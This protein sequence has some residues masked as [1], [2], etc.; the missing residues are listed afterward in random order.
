MIGIEEWI[1]DLLMSRGALVESGEDGR[2]R[3][4]LPSDVAAPLGTGEW[5]SLDFRPVPGGDDAFEWMERMEHILP[6]HPLLVG[7]RMRGA[8]P[9][10]ALDATATLASELAIQNGI[11]RLVDDYSTTAPYLVFTFRYTVESDERSLGFFTACLNADACSIVAQPEIF[12]NGIREFLEEDHWAETP[13][14]MAKH[15]PAAA[16]AA[17]A[18]IR[19]HVAQIEESAN[20]RLARDTARVEAYYQGLLAQIGKRAARRANDPDAAQKERSRAEATELDRLA[21][22]EDLRRKYSLKIETGLAMLLRVRVPVRRIAVRLIRKKEERAFLLDWN[23]VL[24]SLDAPI[25]ERCSVRAHP[26]YLCEQIHCL[27]RDCWAQ[28][29]ACMRFFCR[30]CQP[31]CKCG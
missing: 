20:R 1:S 23:S 3:A 16:R 4:M 25:C 15:Y 2:I 24:R 28:C 29:P 7:A 26:L 27:C 10:P 5:L 21:K 8:A 9:T 18:A 17:R 19:K 6:S 30:V 12:L 13:A 14:D 31:R 11:Y 22:L